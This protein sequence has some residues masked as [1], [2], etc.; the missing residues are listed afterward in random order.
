MINVLKAPE[1][2]WTMCD[3]MSNFNREMKTTRKNQ[4]EMLENEKHGNRNEECF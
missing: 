2:K 3:Q 1:E 4:M